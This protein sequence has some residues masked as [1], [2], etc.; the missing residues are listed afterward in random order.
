MR[1]VLVVGNTETAAIDGLSGA[2]ASPSLRRHTPAADAEILTYGQPVFTPVTPVSPTGCPTPAVVTRA[3]REQLGFPVLPVGAGL[4]AR[5]GAPTLT[6]GDTPGAEI[7]ADVAV[8][9]A[10]GLRAR[11]RELGGALPDERLL[12][13]ESIPGGTTTA[14]GVF[15]ALGEPYAVSSSLPEN[16]LARKREVV[17]AGLAASGLELGATAGAPTQALTMMG[18]PVLAVL[19]GLVEGATASGGTVILA[20]GTQ[21][22]AVAALVRHS[23]VTAPMSLVTTCFL[24]DDD[25]ADIRE[26]AAEFDVSVRLAGERIAEQTG[27][28]FDRFRAGEAKEGVGMGGALAMARQADVSTATLRTAIE[29]CYDRVVTSDGS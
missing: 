5:T 9:D 3:V 21:M 16:P 25:S 11:G 6:V 8:P 23:G 24:L 28:P 18:D 20:G 27:P 29:R 12:L 4:A 14:M 19:A 13:A 1:F 26:A 17:T 10:A 7:R 2:G 22:L 15:R